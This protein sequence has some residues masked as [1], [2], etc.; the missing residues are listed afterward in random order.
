MLYGARFTP[1]GDSSLMKIRLGLS[2]LKASPCVELDH[3]QH[4]QIACVFQSYLA[5]LQKKHFNREVRQPRK[6]L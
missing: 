6:E 4:E 3:L 1:L 5:W 2:K